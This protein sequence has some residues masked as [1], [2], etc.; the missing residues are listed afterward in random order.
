METANVGKDIACKTGLAHRYAEME[1]CSHWL[2]M[3]ATT[4]AAM[5]V[6]QIVVCRINTAATT[7]LLP[8]PRSAP[9]LADTSP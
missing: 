4:L 8:L 7:G 3:T 9:T 1:S 5:A 6:L 2:V